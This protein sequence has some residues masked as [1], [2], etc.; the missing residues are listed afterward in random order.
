MIS[1]FNHQRHMAVDAE[2]R[3]LPHWVP[4]PVD[5]RERRVAD[6]PDV[7]DELTRNLMPWAKRVLLNR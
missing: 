3:L 7:A 5:G 6:G 4:D 1:L 2:R